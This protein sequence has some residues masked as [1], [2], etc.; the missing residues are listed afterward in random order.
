MTPR[1]KAASLYDIWHQP[2]DFEADIKLHRTT[3]HVI[4]TENEFLVGRAVDKNATEEAIKSPHVIF[5]KTVENAW[6]IWIYVGD[7]A[8]IESL[9]PYPLP[10]VGWARRNRSIRWYDQ[11]EFAAK[12]N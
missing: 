4:E 2:R 9:M 3:G 7:I 11:K 1:D 5:G 6:F 12:I 8:K 10:H